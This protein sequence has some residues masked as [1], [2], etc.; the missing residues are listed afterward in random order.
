MAPAKRKLIAEIDTLSKKVM[1]LSVNVDEQK[2]ELAAENMSCA[3][4]LP[5][6]LEV[7]RNEMV[8]EKLNSLTSNANI[9]ILKKATGHHCRRKR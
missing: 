5:I 4:G 7:E 6:F 3:P 9:W 1:Q 8:T 2:S